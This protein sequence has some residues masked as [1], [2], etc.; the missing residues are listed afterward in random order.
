MAAVAAMDP[1]TGEND[2]QMQLRKAIVAIM[3]DKSLTEEE[4]A[5]KRQALLMGGWSAKTEGDKKE[6]KKE[7]A[8]G[9]SIP[10]SAGLICH[11]TG[12]NW[13]GVQPTLCSVSPT[14]VQRQCRGI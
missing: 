4:K 14:P 5:K 7:S 3:M 13:L 1:E 8:K 11:S 6:D 10:R 2:K 12:S 9:G